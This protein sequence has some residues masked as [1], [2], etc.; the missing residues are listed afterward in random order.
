MV[1]WLALTEKARKKWHS[2]A[3]ELGHERLEYVCSHSWNLAA[4][5]R[6]SVYPTQ[7]RGFEDG[8]RGH[9]M[10]KERPR[11][12]NQGAR[13]MHEPGWH[14]K[15]REAQ[16]AHTDAHH[17]RYPW[18]NAR[19]VTEAIL[20][21]SVPA[22]CPSQHHVDPKQAS[23]IKMCLSSWPTD[24][25]ATPKFGGGLLY[26]SIFLIQKYYD[27]SYN[28]GPPNIMIPYVYSPLVTRYCYISYQATGRSLWLPLP[29]R[30]CKS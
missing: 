24:L 6:S 16:S 20:G 25:W 7:A 18:W 11:G 17:L 19:H 23:P 30:I 3:L 15:K 4:M 29:K 5:E 10:W 26:S 14:H 13:H 21:P 2:V 28:N 8:S 12:E 9:T 22:S 27:D 1:S